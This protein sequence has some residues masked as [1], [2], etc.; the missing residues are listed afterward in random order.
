MLTEHAVLSDSALARTVTFGPARTKS[1]PR[2]AALV[3]D[4]QG[5]EAQ[6]FALRARKAVMYST[7]YDHEL[8]RLLLLVAEKSQAIRIAGGT[9]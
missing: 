4:R 3:A 1:D 8:E 2:V 5:L 7:A 9:P 6:V